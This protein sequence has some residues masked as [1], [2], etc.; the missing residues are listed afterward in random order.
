MAIIDRVK[1]DGR[2]DILAWKYPSE[3]LSTWTQLIVNQSQCAVLYK[4]GQALDAFGPGRHTLS[5][6]N[7]PIL[8]HAVNLPFGGQTPFSAEV[9][10]VNL[11][12]NLDVKW[13]TPSPIQ[14]QD[15]KYGIFVPIRANGRFGLRIVEPRQ[16]LTRLVGT[17]TSFSAHDVARY[18]RGL[19][20]TRI[21]DA[22][23]TY[24]TQH[25]ISILEINTYLDELSEYMR[26]RLVPFLAEYGIGLVNFFVNDISFPEDDPAIVRLRDALAKRAE[27]NVVGYS[28]VQERTFD[29][30]EGAAT[31]QGGGAA[32]VMGAGMGLG[33]GFGM[34]AGMGEAFSSMSRQLST[35]DSAEKKCPKCGNAIDARHRFCGECGSEVL[36][37]D[38]I[39]GGTAN[40]C[41]QCGVGIPLD[42]KFCPECG[43]PQKR[44]CKQCG[45]EASSFHKF[46]PECGERLGD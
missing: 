41:T 24:F 17:L 15:P 14:V 33:M 28:Y 6:Q 10:F 8:C 2:P 45:H 27:M 7:I 21:K 12:D 18:F 5:T 44:K 16:F 36:S 37:R 40:T 20:V 1:Y 29:T 22:I 31:N 9:W 11:V 39:A 26:E 25:E 19:Y 38:S 3:E 13:G 35:A 42:A 32:S 23:S 34:G 46:C 43:S 30:L 4:G